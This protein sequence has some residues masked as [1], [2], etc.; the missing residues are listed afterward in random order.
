[1]RSSVLLREVAINYDFRTCERRSTRLMSCQARFSLEPLEILKTPR[2][3]P[4]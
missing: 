1:M 4:I 2:E 3:M